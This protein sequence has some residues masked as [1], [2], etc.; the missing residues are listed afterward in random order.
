MRRRGAAA[1]RAAPPHSARFS[2][3][4]PCG[5]ERAAQARQQMQEAASTRVDKAH[6]ECHAKQR[7]AHSGEAHGAVRVRQHI[8]H[9]ISKRAQGVSSRMRNCGGERVR[10]WVG[11]APV[12][13]LD[14]LDPQRVHHR[15]RRAPPRRPRAAARA[16]TQGA[17]HL[18]ART[19]A[20]QAR[21]APEG[22]GR[23]QQRVCPRGAAVGQ[24][25]GGRQPQRPWHAAQHDR[26]VSQRVRATAAQQPASQRGRMRA[27]SSS[28][29]RGLV[30]SKP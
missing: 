17:T 8:Q 11:V 24:M 10:A 4:P 1:P 13:A 28:T 2:A 7:K 25:H 3:R 12:H 19:H 21:C 23:A 26:S 18:D 30:K 14:H 5:R 27:H 9:C 15:R 16:T 20:E 22:A 6:H 29:R